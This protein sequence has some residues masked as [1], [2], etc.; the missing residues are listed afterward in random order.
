MLSVTNLKPWCLQ[1]KT[2]TEPG[3]AFQEEVRQSARI[4]NLLASAPIPSFHL[5]KNFTDL[6]ERYLAERTKCPLEGKFAKGTQNLNFRC[7]GSCTA[8]SKVY[9]GKEVNAGKVLRQL[10]A[11][12]GT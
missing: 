12:R 5:G 11:I 9:R 4:G 3:S 7:R 1:M 2:L 8:W 10:D 6:K